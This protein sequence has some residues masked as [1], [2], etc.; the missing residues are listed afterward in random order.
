MMAAR[1]CCACRLDR[2]IDVRGAAQGGLADR[3]L[4][5]RVDDVDETAVGGL[6]PRST[7]VEAV[8]PHLTLRRRL[9]HGFTLLLHRPTHFL[10]QANQRVDDLAIK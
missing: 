6:D 5:R 1:E 4:G 3:F 7:D 8:V 10:I 2:A 9:P